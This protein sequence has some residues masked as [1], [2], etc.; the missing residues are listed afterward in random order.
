MDSLWLRT[1]AL[2]IRAF[3]GLCLYFFSPPSFSHTMSYTQKH[4]LS[5]RTS[6]F[7]SLRV[8]VTAMWPR[9]PP[10]PSPLPPPPLQARPCWYKRCETRP[11]L[12]FVSRLPSSSRLLKRSEVR[13]GSRGACESHQR[14]QE[15][16]RDSHLWLS[17]RNKSEASHLLLET[18]SCSCCSSALKGPECAEQSAALTYWMSAAPITHT[19]SAFAFCSIATACT[20]VTKR[21]QLMKTRKSS[22]CSKLHFL[23][24]REHKSRFQ[25]PV[26]WISRCVCS[27]ALKFHLCLQTVRRVR[28]HCDVPGALGMLNLLQKRCWAL[29][30]ICVSQMSDT[31]TGAFHR[32][33]L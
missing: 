32:G 4:K 23:S 25:V 28:W 22:N 16:Q 15:V 11:F 14:E 1:L 27:A 26:N 6:G 21:S 17:P 31:K 20:S 30:S 9:W 24:N 7:F 33:P 2:C 12:F 8:L 19:S 5:P 3:L 10:S 29:M 13:P 18:V